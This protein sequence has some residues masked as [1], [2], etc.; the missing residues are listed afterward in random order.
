MYAPDQAKVLFKH[1]TSKIE[2]FIVGGVSYANEAQTINKEFP[3][4]E[5]IGFEPCPETFGS[6]SNELAFPGKLYPYALWYENVTK[7]LYLMG[8][9]GRMSRICGPRPSNIEIDKLSVTARTLDSLSEELGPWS[10]IA[11]WLDI[12][13]AEEA[14]LQGATDLLERTLLINIE[15]NNSERELPKFSSLLNPHGIYLAETWNTDKMPD[16]VDAIFLRK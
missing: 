5:C 7:D 3:D 2:Y 13:F 11:L 8:K 10:N 16:R 6:Q 14:A 1:W 9:N 15:V 12:E 4:V